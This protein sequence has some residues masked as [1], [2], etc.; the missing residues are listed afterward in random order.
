[1]F[2]TS[3]E[4]PIVFRQLKYGKMG[5]QPTWEAAMFTVSWVNQRKFEREIE[6]LQNNEVADNLYDLIRF[7]CIN[8]GA[9][10]S[11]DKA[12]Q[13]CY[14]QLTE[15]SKGHRTAQQKIIETASGAPNVGSF[16][17]EPVRA[18]AKNV[19]ELSP[20]GKSNTD[21][22]YIRVDYDGTDGVVEFYGVGHLR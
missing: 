15:L 9:P 2:F 3:G 22:F 16:H 8:W 17:Y 6:A 19:I 10:T 7:D 4:K 1:M 11:V 18:R 21:R 20:S 13:I 12:V 5:T 14:Q